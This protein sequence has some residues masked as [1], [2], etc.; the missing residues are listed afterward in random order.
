MLRQI[1]PGREDTYP[2]S[3]KV[4]GC[5]EP[6]KG[7]LQKLCGSHL[8]QKLLASVVYTLTSAEYLVE[9][10][11]QDVSR[12]CSGNPSRQGGHL[13]SRQSSLCGVR[14]QRCLQQMLSPKEFFKVVDYSLII[15]FIFYFLFFNIFLLHIFLNYISNAIPNVP[16]SLPPLPYPPIPIFVNVPHFLYPFLC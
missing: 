6:E 16:H 10:G 2:L 5:L 11:I 12:R 14:D 1:L 7:L 3:G 13:F 9:F 15:F 4:P 8:F